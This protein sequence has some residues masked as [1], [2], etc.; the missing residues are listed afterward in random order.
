MSA[1]L[2]DGQPIEPTASN[3]SAQSAPKSVALPDSSGEVPPTEEMRF[4]HK[5][6]CQDGA[7]GSLSIE[8]QRIVVRSCPEHGVV[9]RWICQGPPTKAK[10]YANGRIYVECPEQTAE[11][12]RLRES[13]TE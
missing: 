12:A 7:P 8:D 4:L 2:Q 5:V 1:C 9:A 3:R 13:N 6:P 11:W 10:L